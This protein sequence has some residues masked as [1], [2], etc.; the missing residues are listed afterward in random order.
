MKAITNEYRFKDRDIVI[1]YGKHEISGNLTFELTSS[2]PTDDG[3]EVIRTKATLTE[4][5]YDLMLVGMLLSRLESIKY[6]DE[7]EVNPLMYV[8]TQEENA[9]LSL[10]EVLFMNF[11][12]K[13][14]EAEL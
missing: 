1:R 3:S 13:Y 7:L 2:R 9:V 11:S 5:S 6:A 8:D 12:A 10:L 14:K 4:E